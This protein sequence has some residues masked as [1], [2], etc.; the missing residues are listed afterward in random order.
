M[1]YD[2]WSAELGHPIEDLTAADDL[3]PLPRLDSGREGHRR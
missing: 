1:R 2:N 3:T